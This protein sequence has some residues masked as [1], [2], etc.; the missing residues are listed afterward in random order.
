LSRKQFA[1][2]AMSNSSVGARRP[3]KG[4]QPQPSINTSKARGGK[5]Q[6]RIVLSPFPRGSVGQAQGTVSPA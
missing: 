4:T 3:K 6:Q 1:C 5:Q 2:Q